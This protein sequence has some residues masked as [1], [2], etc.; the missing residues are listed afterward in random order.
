MKRIRGT[1]IKIYQLCSY[2]DDC[3]KSL[4]KAKI[5]K[6]NGKKAI[7]ISPQLKGKAVGGSIGMAKRNIN[8]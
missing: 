6:A 1:T 2:F 3:T 7:V 4:D 8:A 5:K